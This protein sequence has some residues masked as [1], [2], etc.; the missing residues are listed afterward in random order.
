MDGKKQRNALTAVHRALSALGKGEGA[1]ARRALGRAV[2]LDQIGVYVQ[3]VEPLDRAALA[4][5]AGD[6]IAPQ[7]W[8][9]I[10]EVLGPG[11]L[12]AVVEDAR[13]R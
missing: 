3:L 2:E 11:P 10:E 8:D 13:S 12:A 1:A 6:Q 7:D 9:Q 5:E 4:L